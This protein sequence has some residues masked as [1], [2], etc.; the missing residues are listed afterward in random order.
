MPLRNVSLTNPQVAGWRASNSI[1]WAAE[2]DMARVPYSLAHDR[3]LILPKLGCLCRLRQRMKQKRPCRG[4]TLGVL[5]RL[6]PRLGHLMPLV[7]KATARFDAGTV[8]SVRHGA[9]KLAL[10]R[11]CGFC[12][13][14]W[15]SEI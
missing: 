12:K 4:D 11:K 7:D 2:R 8:Q 14:A 5:E 15:V 10:P 1:T 6:P 9:A 13:M 3:T